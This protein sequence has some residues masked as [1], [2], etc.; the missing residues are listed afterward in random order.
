MNTVTTNVP[1]R[2]TPYLLGHRMPSCSSTPSGPD[3]AVSIGI[4]GYDGRL[5]IGVTSDYDAVPD[6]DVLCTAIER[7]L[8]DL[9][10]T[11]TT[12]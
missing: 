4:L 5:T 9:V 6:V 3:D 2:S 8:D 1:G 11:T 10:G 12:A 7:S